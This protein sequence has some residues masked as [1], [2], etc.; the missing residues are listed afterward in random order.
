MDDRQD[1]VSALERTFNQWYKDQTVSNIKK[2]HK[3]VR[4][5][6]NY[7]V[8]VADPTPTCG[9]GN[10]V[11]FGYVRTGC[12]YGDNGDCIHCGEGIPF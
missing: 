11:P 8:E 2:L 6:K 9:N 12:E 7:D 10:R 3:A 4:A 5:L 1:L